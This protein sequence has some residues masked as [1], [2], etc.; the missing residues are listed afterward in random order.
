M[1]VCACVRTRART[2]N[3]VCLPRG[4]TSVGG[5]FTGFLLFQISFSVLWFSPWRS[6]FLFRSLCLW[7]VFFG[8]PTQNSCFGG[9]NHM[10]ILSLLSTHL[11]RQESHPNYLNYCFPQTARLYTRRH[12]VQTCRPLQLFFWKTINSAGLSSASLFFFFA[13]HHSLFHFL[14]LLSSHKQKKNLQPKEWGLC[15]EKPIVG[16]FFL[17]EFLKW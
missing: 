9:G 7:F 2:A 16:I 10:C 13:L 5:M 8:P 1:R 15:T 12:S 4:L 17:I 6:F 14:R 11:P 3:V